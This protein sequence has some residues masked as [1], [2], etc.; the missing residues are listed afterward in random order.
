MK[1]QPG[2][3]YFLQGI[4]TAL[5]PQG[6]GEP[7]TSNAC[8]Q[9]STPTGTDVC[10]VAKKYNIP[11]CQLKG[12][13]ELET[14]GGANTGTG[15]CSTNHGIFAC[16]HGSVC[17]PAQVA[18]TQYN[19]FAGKDQI[20]MCDPAG[21][22]ELLARAMLLKLCQADHV[23]DSYDWTKWGDYVTKHYKV[24]DGDY[25]ATAYF[26]GL[27]N[28]CYASACTQYR[29]GVGKGYC[30]SVKS[31]CDNGKVLPDNTTPSFCSACNIELERA[32][33]QPISCP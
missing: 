11:C 32:H 10:S 16:C 14:G 13:E 29:W 17:G 28:G 8:I 18:C 25:T 7:L 23:C 4:Q 12:V 9:Q 30:D 22:A 3:Q 33:Q 2:K 27:Q 20:N 1:V 15:S 19:G 21:G 5:R 24:K 31:Y 26:Y 6:Y